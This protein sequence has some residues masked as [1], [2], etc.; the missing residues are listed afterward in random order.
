MEKGWGGVTDELTI[1]ACAL[2]HTEWVSKK[3]LLRR[4]GNSTRF[5]VTYMGKESVCVCVC[6]CVCTYIYIFSYII[7]KSL[8]YTPETNTIM[9]QP[10]LNKK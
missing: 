7:Y 4:T 3:D 8:N 10:Y 6:V 2:V 9:N 1:V 5:V